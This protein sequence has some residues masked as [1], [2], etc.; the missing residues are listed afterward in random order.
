MWYRALYAKPDT[1]DVINH[2]AG[3]FFRVVQDVLLD[4]FGSTTSCTC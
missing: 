4:G 1:V 3:F 2:T